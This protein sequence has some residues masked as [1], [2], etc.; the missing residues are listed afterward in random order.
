MFLW[1][2]LPKGSLFHRAAGM[3]LHSGSYFLWVFFL[4]LI[5][6]LFN[7]VD[8]GIDDDFEGFDDLDNEGDGDGEDEDVV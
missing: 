8:G 3:L 5:V 4:S 2:H 7:N 1:K 6:F